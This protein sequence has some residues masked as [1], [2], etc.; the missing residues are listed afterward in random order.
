MTGD[1]DLSQALAETVQEANAQGSPLA[2]QGGD[3]KAFYGR[4][5][6]GSILDISPHRG[7]V[8]YEPTELV[9]TARAGTPLQEVQGWLAENGQMLGFE[10]PHFGHCAT[11]GGT[12]ASGLSGPRRPYTGAV[13]DVILGVKLINGVG[14]ILQFGGQVVKNVAGYDISRLM[15]GSLGTLGVIL[16]VSIK[17]F[18][19]PPV[20]TTLVQEFV[21]EQALA[22]MARWAREP[23]PISATCYDGQNLFIR[24]SGNSRAVES[25]TKRLGG[26]ELEAPEPFWEGI[27]EHTAPFFQTECPLWRLS[28][29]PT[30]PPLDLPGT[31]LLEWG[32]ALRWLPSEAPATTIRE[33]VS[34]VG[35][36]ASLFRGGE[37]DG[38]VFHPLPEALMKW[39]KNL[40]L[41]FDPH[42]ILNPGRIYPEL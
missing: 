39:H 20:E 21:A 31:P 6:H 18:P 41:A 16:E 7:L 12:V 22:A 38:T 2:I 29:P 26:E 28:V 27:R 5:T 8:S 40:K 23:L 14:E 37:R 33:T 9:I 35:G 17:L 11:L 42:T 19:R 34:Q 3:T 24:L 30:T 32:G 4:P 1:R 13:R 25:A 36:H 15:A 10:P